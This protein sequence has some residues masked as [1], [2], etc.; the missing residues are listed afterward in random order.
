MTPVPGPLRALR[1]AHPAPWKFWIAFDGLII[2]RHPQ[3]GAGEYLRCGT[4]EE[5]EAGIADWEARQ[6]ARGGKR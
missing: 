2:G 5:M 3:M 6:R 4:A 1:S